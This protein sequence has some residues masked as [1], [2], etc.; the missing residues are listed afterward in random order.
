MFVILQTFWPCFSFCNQCMFL[1]HFFFNLWCLLLSF[2]FSDWGREGTLHLKLALTW[3]LADVVT[4]LLLCWRWTIMDSAI[5]IL[6]FLYIISNNAK[7]NIIY[8]SIFYSK[9]H[10]V[11]Q[12]SFCV[13]CL[14]VRLCRAL[15][16]SSHLAFEP[17]EN[18]PARN[19]T[20]PTLK[21]FQY[22]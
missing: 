18:T 21:F 16:F 17:F 20:L 7:P 5:A 22:I 1:F 2:A 12:L 4:T 19:R 9:L 15:F 13:H 14:C 10:E 3:V 11:S 6:D 8:M